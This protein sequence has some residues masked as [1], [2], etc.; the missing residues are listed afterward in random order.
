MPVVATK[1][2]GRWLTW[3]MVVVLVASV[4]I[5][6]AGRE[7]LPRRI[8]VATG[9]EGGLYRA[10]GTELKPSLS[11]RLGRAADVHK[12]AGSV[13]NAEMLK[14]GGADLAVVQGGSIAL[15]ELSVV[16]PLYP[17]LVLVIVRKDRNISHQSPEGTPRSIP[18][19]DATD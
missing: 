8:V 7:T 6:F 10:L 15:D 9:E 16:T 12:T 2:L 13:Q 4:V 18:G 3:S 14:L 5:R 17:E 11:R 1:S 19:R